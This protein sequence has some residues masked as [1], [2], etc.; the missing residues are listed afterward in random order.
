MANSHYRPVPPS[1]PRSKRLKPTAASR[2]D[3]DVSRRPKSTPRSEY[4]FMREYE[5]ICGTQP[6]RPA[7]G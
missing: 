1:H 5:L 4:A 6:S 7:R 2:L 3:W